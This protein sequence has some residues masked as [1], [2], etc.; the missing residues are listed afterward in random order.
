MVDE[1]QE[2]QRLV[3]ISG[4]SDV[5]GLWNTYRNVFRVILGSLRVPGAC[6]ENTA[7]ENLIDFFFFFA[8]WGRG[9]S[10]NSILACLYIFKTAHLLSLSS[11]SQPLLY[12][13]ITRAAFKTW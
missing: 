5:S 2:C 8:R 11:D 7:G 12:S 4:Y 10:E 6:V 3:S 13:R 1:A 9:E